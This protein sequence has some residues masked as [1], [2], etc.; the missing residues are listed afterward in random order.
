LVVVEAAALEML[1][2]LLQV[3]M[4]LLDLVAMGHH[5][6]SLDLQ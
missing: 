1:E 3:V 6:Q 5:H 4:L 2:P